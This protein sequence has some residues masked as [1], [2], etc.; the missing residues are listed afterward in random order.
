M[1]HELECL[2]LLQA[3]QIAPLPG[4]T[5]AQ[6][7]ARLVQ[8]ADTV[9]RPYRYPALEDARGAFQTYWQNWGRRELWTLPGGYVHAD[10]FNT[11]QAGHAA[12][13]SK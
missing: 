8:V 11:F 10:I 12:R 3:L 9:L 1:Q 2:A 13:G 5:F 6:A 7:V 4:E